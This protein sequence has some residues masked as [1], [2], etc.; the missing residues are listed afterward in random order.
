MNYTEKQILQSKTAHQFIDR[1]LNSKVHRGHKVALCIEWLKKTGYTSEDVKYA[2]HRHPYWKAMKLRGN[3]ERNKKR[4]KQFNFFSGKSSRRWTKKEIKEF[5]QYNK[6]ED[7]GK[8]KNTD[9]VIASKMQISIG[10]VQGWRRKFNMIE[11]LTKSRKKVNIMDML[12]I[13][14]NE[15]RRKVKKLL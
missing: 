1:C 4:M 15:L 7:D 13:G 5:I 12:A 11:R 9:W 10:A 8:Y 6:K 2:R 3:K 14:E